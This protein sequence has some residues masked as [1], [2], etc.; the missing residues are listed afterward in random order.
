VSE[1][2]LER[3]PETPLTVWYA[4]IFG[5]T[6]AEAADT[7]AAPPITAP[8]AT[9]TAAE[10]LQ[11]LAFVISFF[12]LRVSAAWLRNGYESVTES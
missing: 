8:H 6:A 5:S 9:A 2:T 3:L 12:L 7:G 10:V 4:P 1:P 11:R